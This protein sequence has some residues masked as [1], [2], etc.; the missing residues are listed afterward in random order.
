MA[1]HAANACERAESSRIR[2]R[3]AGLTVLVLLLMLA[4]GA[5]AHAQG[6]VGSDSSTRT[7]RYRHDL[8]YGTA[9]GF[10][11]AGV[12]QLRNDPLEWGKGWHGYERR[13]ASDVGEFIVQESVTDLLASAMDRQ[14]DYQRC[15]CT[16]TGKRIGWALQSSVTDPLPNGRRAIAIPRIAGAFAGSFAQA[17]W[18]PA[19]TSSRTRTALVNG[20]TSLAIGAGIN[21]FYELRDR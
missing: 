20:V 15:R 8:V 4:P 11:Y 13:L 9:L 10:V 3:R 12:D 18:R 5:I 16:G 6:R 2:P 19:G 14:L 7:R 1:H 21:L 17:G